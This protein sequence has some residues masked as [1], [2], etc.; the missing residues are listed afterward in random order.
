MRLNTLWPA[1]LDVLFPPRC[2]VAGCGVRGGWLCAGCLAGI[3][4]LPPVRCPRCGDATA[5]PGPCPGCRRDP[6]RFDRVVA[7]GVYTSPLRDAIHAL[8]FHG[9]AQVAPLLGVLAAAALVE[10]AGASGQGGGFGQGSGIGAVPDRAAGVVVPVPSH[11]RRTAARGVDHTH[12]LAAAV[13][14]ALDLPL[15]P[16]VLLRVRDTRPQVGLAPGERR[17]NVEGAF[18]V[19]AFE[20]ATLGSARCVILVDDVMTT[21]ATTRACAAALAAG[22]ARRVVVCAVARAIATVDATGQGPAGWL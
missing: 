19:A 1:F 18:A 13:A 22:G 4:P 9:Q 21:G 2:V 14:R 11:P 15:A 12:C 7:A 17:R 8:K 5:G 16:G 20:V 10:G 6:P 3:A